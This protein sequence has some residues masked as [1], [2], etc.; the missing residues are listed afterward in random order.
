MK[1]ILLTVVTLMVSAT[2]LLNAKSKPDMEQML[3]YDRPAQCWLEA[4]PLGNSRMGAMV[5]GKTDIEQI[6]CRDNQT[7]Q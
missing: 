7:M 2:T 1:K 5:Y 3:W 4:L 6:P